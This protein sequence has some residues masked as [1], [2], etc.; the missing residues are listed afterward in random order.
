MAQQAKI[1]AVDVRRNP[2][3]T[4]ERIVDAYRAAEANM[5]AAADL[6][7]VARS[8]VDRWVIDLEK[9]SGCRMRSRLRSVRRDF[10]DK[11]EERRVEAGRKGGLVGHG[12]RPRKD[13]HRDGE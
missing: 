5:G 12:G 1:E 6:L 3:E 7:G 11:I 8:T 10:A 9:T 2:H 13:A 4:V